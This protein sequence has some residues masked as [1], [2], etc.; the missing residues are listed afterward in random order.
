[1]LAALNGK[2]KNGTDDLDRFAYKLRANG[3]CS[4][5]CGGGFMKAVPTCYDL[6]RDT[7]LPEPYCAH[8]PKPSSYGHKLPCNEGV[9]CPPK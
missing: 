7:Y 8:L 3:T 6:W 5:S 4:V 1:M 2:A 9:P